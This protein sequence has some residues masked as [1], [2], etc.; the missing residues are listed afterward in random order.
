[1]NKKCEILFFC[2]IFVWGNCFAQ[3]TTTPKLRL[4]LIE[5]VFKPADSNYFPLTKVFIPN[6]NTAPFLSADY[7]AK[8]LGFFCKQEIK[9]DKLTKIPF[10]FRLGSVEQCNWLEG[11]NKIR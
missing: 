10:R 2:M 9:F 6:S 5:Q 1:M 4:T 8:Q 7:Y 11:K 3:F